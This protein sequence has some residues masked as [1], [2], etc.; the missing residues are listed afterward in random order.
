[1]DQPADE[2]IGQRGQAELPA[3]LVEHVEPRRGR[4]QRDVGVAAV[5]GQVH[6]RLRHEGRAQSVLLRDRLDH[7]LEEGVLVGRPQTVVVFPV[8]LELAVRVLMIILVGVP[9][10]RDH[11]VADV[12]DDVVAAHGAVRDRR[13]IGRDQEVLALDAGLHLVAVLGGLCHDALQDLARIL[14]DRLAVHHEIA[15]DP[16]HLG[17]PRKLDDGCRVGSDED[18]GVGR[19]HVEPRRKTGKS[20]AGLRHSIDGRC[21]YE[22][23]AHH[24]EQVDEGHQEILDALFLRVAA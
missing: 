8:H 13:A 15:R 7:V 10:Q 4:P 18:V 9:A 2:A 6:E 16:R 12:L 24:T 20:G 5:A 17:L 19:R 22:L 3:S 11:A 14:L 21:G 1:M 23:R